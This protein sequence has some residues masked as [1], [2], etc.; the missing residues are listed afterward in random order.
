MKRFVIV[1]VASLAIVA[2]T[3]SEKSTSVVTCPAADVADKT[4]IT[5]ERAQ[6]LVG[7]AEKDAE[8]C[9]ADLGWAY[10]VGSRDGESFAV[11]ADFSQQRVTV[12]VTLGVV[13]A[14]S[15]G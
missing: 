1:V 4:A 6:L 10:R 5:A 13:T 9:A 15:V 8:N 14:I 11:T 7:F 12:V 2:C 3:S